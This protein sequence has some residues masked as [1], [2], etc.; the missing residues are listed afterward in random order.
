LAEIG[1]PFI[2]EH[3]TQVLAEHDCLI[4]EGDLTCRPVSNTSTTHPGVVFGHINDE[5]HPFRAADHAHQYRTSNP[6]H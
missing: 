6:T 3:I 5:A 4:R 2:D 1:R